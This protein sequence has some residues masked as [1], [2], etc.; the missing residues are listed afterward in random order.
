MDVDARDGQ[1][2]GAIDFARKMHK[3]SILA[4]LQGVKD[5][6]V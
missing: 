3:K 2:F 5:G 4:L 1:G 6:T